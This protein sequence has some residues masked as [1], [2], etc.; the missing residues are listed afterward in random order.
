MVLYSNN[1][2]DLT[3][4]IQARNSLKVP[5]HPPKT[6]WPINGRN[7]DICVYIYMSKLQKMGQKIDFFGFLKN[8][9]EVPQIS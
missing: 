6:I 3:T 1:A 8:A 4:A 5:K 9:P 2:P 7:H